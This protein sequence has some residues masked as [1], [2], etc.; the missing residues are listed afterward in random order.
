[1]TVCFD[2]YCAR[3]L[4]LHCQYAPTQRLMIF[5]AFSLSGVRPHVN[6]FMHVIRCV[7]PCTLIKHEKYLPCRQMY[8]NIFSSNPLLLR[9]LCSGA[10]LLGQIFLLCLVRCTMDM[11]VFPF[12]RSI[13]D[14]FSKYNGSIQNLME[15]LDAC[16]SYAS[17]L[18]LKMSQI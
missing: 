17:K 5:G 9:Y 1:M 14:L 4:I 6:F 16:V 12:F 7:P 2:L 15:K 8:V 11:L 13:Y 18:H 10:L 3:M